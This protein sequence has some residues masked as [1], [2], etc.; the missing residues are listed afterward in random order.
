MSGVRAH[1]PVHQLEGPK[2]T[3]QMQG[4][5]AGPPECYAAPGTQPWEGW[6]RRTQGPQHNSDRQRRRYKGVRKGSADPN[7]KKHRPDSTGEG[8]EA[9]EVP[10]RAA[11]SVPRGLSSSLFPSWP[12]AQFWVGEKPRG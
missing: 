3:Q 12:Q 8:Q 6:Q 9:Q 10:P 11:L 2:A 7:P 4:E 1:P 5:A